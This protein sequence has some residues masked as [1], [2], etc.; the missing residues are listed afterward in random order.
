MRNKRNKSGCGFGDEIVS[1][2]Y[3]E[4]AAADRDRFESHLVTCTACTDEFAAIA[5]A[6]YSVFDWRKREFAALE[7]PAIVIPYDRVDIQ[8]ET[9]GA[10]AAFGEMVRSWRLAFA[11]GLI[12]VAAVTVLTLG[13]LSTPQQVTVS[14]VPSKINAPDPVQNISS[15]QKQVDV[16]KPV[17][18]SV[19]HV[20]LRPYTA[21]PL[22]A[23]AIKPVVRAHTALPASTVAAQTVKSVVNKAP[24]LSNYEENEDKSLRL[25]DLFDTEVGVR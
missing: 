16:A 3:D 17:I 19:K 24:V 14:S 10:F 25:A 12:A 21:R 1:Y 23:Q 4:L 7:T 22:K 11:T 9:I 18:E 8:T 6:R 13:Y 2:M 5:D 20:D 15:E